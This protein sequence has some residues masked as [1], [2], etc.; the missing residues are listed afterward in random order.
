MQNGAGRP[1]ASVTGIWR[2][3][4]APNS[5][6]VEKVL[7][8]KAF[9]KGSKAETAILFNSCSPLSRNAENHDQNKLHLGRFEVEKVIFL[10]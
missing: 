2:G 3:L 9:L 5:A 4:V 10:M 1:L 7:V 8:F 6:N